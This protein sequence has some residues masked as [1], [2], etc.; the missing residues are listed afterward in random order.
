[1]LLFKT[2]EYFY[3]KMDDLQEVE[4]W[5]GEAIALSQKHTMEE[6]ENKEAKEQEG[7]G[8]SGSPRRGRSCGLN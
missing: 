5:R 8:N 4:R 7:E 3:Q 1:M 2:L 6:L